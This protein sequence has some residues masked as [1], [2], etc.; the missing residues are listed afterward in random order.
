MNIDAD[1]TKTTKISFGING[2]EQ[3]NS[4]PTVSTGRLFELVHYASPILP[5]TFSN[6]QG[7]D[8]VWGDVFQSGTSRTNVSQLFTQLSIEQELSF[9]PGT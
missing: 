2:T 3:L 9:I 4:A 5:L 7:G 1:V 8:Y 6:G